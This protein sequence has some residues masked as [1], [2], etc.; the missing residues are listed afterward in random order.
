MSRSG[1]SEFDDYDPLAEG[2]WRAAIRS[3][4]R[5]KRGQAF[6]REALT[7]L[8]AMPEKKLIREHLVFDGWQ[9]KW[10]GD[11]IIVG[12]DVLCDRTGTE[13]PIGSVCLLGAVGKARGLDMT[14]ID[15]ED[16]DTVAPM[17][18]IANAMAR[19]IVDQNDEGGH[20]RETPEARWQRMRKWISSQIIIDHHR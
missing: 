5:G 3:A 19:N 10:D 8:D 20:H 9:P 15:P 11:E 7:A 13:M 16:I 14:S 1:L 18:G 17:F 6:L 2:R 4:T 12:G